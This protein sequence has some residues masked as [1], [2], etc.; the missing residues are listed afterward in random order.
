MIAY[1]IDLMYPPIKMLYAFASTLK[2]AFFI[3]VAKVQASSNRPA[4]VNPEIMVKYMTASG[5]CP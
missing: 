5:G 1:K 2:P 3:D 4:C